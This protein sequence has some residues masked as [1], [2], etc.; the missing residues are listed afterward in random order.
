M[1]PLAAHH[2]VLHAVQTERPKPAAVSA[3]TAAGEAA[4][5]GSTAGHSVDGGSGS[6]TVRSNLQKLGCKST[7]PT[8]PT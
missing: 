2:C 4:I 1:A 3:A 6:A 5:V 8:R 7:D